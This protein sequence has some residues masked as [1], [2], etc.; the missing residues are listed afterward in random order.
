MV[1]IYI[2]Y[3]IFQIGYLFQNKLQ[4]GLP[5][6]YRSCMTK[7]TSPVGPCPTELA[8][9]PH[10]TAEKL[11]PA[12]CC[13]CFL[14]LFFFLFFFF[15]LESIKKIK[16]RLSL[17][18]SVLMVLSNYFYKILACNPLLHK[19]TKVPIALS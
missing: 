10:A 3:L 14:L 19:K 12:F 13:C 16:K 1:F 4:N 11:P 15:Y 5:L 2:R 6:S 7:H 17:V 9:L 8:E 18:S